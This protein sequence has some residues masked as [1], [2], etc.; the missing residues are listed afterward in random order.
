MTIPV[1]GDNWIV[2][3]ARHPGVTLDP[4]QHVLRIVMDDQLPNNWI[5]NFDAIRIVR[6][7]FVVPGPPIEAEDFDEGGE[8]VGYHDTTSGNAGSG[9]Y[10]RPSDVDLSVCPA[11]SQ[12]RVIVGYVKAGEWLRYSVDIA[13]AGA[14]VIEVRG[15]AG[16]TGGA[17]HIEIDGV[18]RS[19]PFAV[20]DTGS[21]WIAGTVSTGGISLTAGSHVV[22]MVMDQE[23]AHTWVGNFDRLQFIAQ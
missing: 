8:G 17:F 23:A 12:C 7:P 6:R 21:S 2:G 4:G 10:Y 3:A 13:T 16:S 20:P 19:G 11:D 5:G 18:D 9:V 1:T 22:R 14:Y 15:T